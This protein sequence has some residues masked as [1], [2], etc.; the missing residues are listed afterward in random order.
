MRNRERLRE[1][2]RE[3]ERKRQREK[4]ASCRDPDTGQDPGP[5]GSHPGLK[6][7]LNR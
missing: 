7:V 3:R 4:Q 6:E 5:P 1:R 2:E